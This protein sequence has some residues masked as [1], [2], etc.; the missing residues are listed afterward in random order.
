LRMGVG[1][2]NSRDS[3]KIYTN[4]FKFDLTSQ[5]NESNQIKTGFELIINQHDIKYGAIEKTLPS[6]RPFSIWDVSPIRAGLYL[7]DKFEFKGLIAN[8]GLRLDYSHAGLEWFDIDEY[9]KAFYSAD[10][11]TTGSTD[12]D[13][14]KKQS[15]HLWYLS[16]RLGISHPITSNSKLYFNYGHFRS[17]PEAQSLYNVQRVTEGTVSR[18]G[19]PNNTLSKTV[20]YELGYEHNLFNQFLL[21]LAAYYKDV[22]NNIPN[23]TSRWVKYISADRKVNYYK[24]EDNFYEDIRGFEIS[25]RRTFGRYVTGFV[26]YTYMVNTS[27]YFGKLFYY[28]NPAEQRD[29]DRTNIYQEKPLPRPYFRANLIFRT[30]QDFGPELLKGFDL[31]GEWQLSL[32]TSWKEGRYETWTRGV[33]LPGIEYNVQWPDYMNTNMKLS[34]N[35]RLGGFSFEL[36]MDI[37]N[38]FNNKNF[39]SYAFVDGNDKRDYYDSLLWPK[40]IGEPLGYTV[41]GDDKIGDL[42]PSDVEYDPLEANPDNDPEIAARNEKRIDSKSYINN[43]NLDWLY[44]L[45]PRS[46][47]FGLR[48]NL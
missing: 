25:L 46:I 43:P 17:M 41:F 2:S 30:P 39:T 18:I 5:V 16:P 21:R 35:L 20:A 10:F 6:G 4:T 23:S 26:N 24:A 38:L 13:F 37:N 34:K 45:N 19:D 22:S 15:E 27:G 42:R 48:I 31:L 32:V 29:Y 8:V 11:K 36:F 12:D 28:E 44:Y 40:E 9:D 7:Q 14:E 3:S 1:M 33:S 47:V